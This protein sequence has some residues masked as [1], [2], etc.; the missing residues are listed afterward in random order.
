M[1]RLR[2]GSRLSNLRAIARD[3]RGLALTEFA[4]VLPILL[5]IGLAGLETANLAM[6]HLRVSNIA[7]QAADNAA[8]VRESIDEKDIIELLNGARDTGRSIRFMERGRIVISSLERNPADSG[9]WIRW[10]RCNGVRSFT[11]AY[12]AEDAGRTNASIQSVGSPGRQIS[13]QPDTAIILVEVSYEYLPLVGAQIFG[14]PELRYESAFI[15]RQRT[16]QA[17]RNAQN[18][19]RKLCNVYTAA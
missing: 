7:T 13:A 16:D 8:R 15:V 17:I 5:F 12:G 1:L 10:Q 2:P 4:F 3:T 19:T 18:L 9:Q 14:R 11:S 6:T